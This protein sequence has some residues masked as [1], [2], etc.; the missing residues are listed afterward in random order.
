MVTL[1][2]LV[3]MAAC[4]ALELKHADQEVEP[5]ESVVMSRAGNAYEQVASLESHQSEVSRDVK[6]AVKE[7][8]ARLG[9]AHYCSY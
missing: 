3:R 1:R 2:L 6:D 5:K 9:E 7:V 4:R 8:S